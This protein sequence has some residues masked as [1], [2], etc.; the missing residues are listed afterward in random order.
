MVEEF[1]ESVLDLRHLH[2]RAFT[3]FRPNHGSF[4][5]ITLVT[6]TLYAKGLADIH[7]SF[8]RSDDDVLT[9]MGLWLAGDQDQSD[10]NLRQLVLSD[11]REGPEKA[12]NQ[13]PFAIKIKW[14]VEGSSKW[15]YATP[16]VQGGKGI[17]RCWAC[18]LVDEKLPYLWN[19]SGGEK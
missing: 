9:V 5:Q 10:H 14:G 13:R 16:M 19:K 8:G 4:W 17:C 1:H 11:R 12:R 15:L 6:R 7:V 2:K 3:L 18:F